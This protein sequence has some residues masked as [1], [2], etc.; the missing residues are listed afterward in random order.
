MYGLEHR[1]REL[2]PAFEVYTVTLINIMKEI[3][4]QRRKN[5]LTVRGDNA[6]GE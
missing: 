3:M 2:E 4:D 6:F 5:A 1:D